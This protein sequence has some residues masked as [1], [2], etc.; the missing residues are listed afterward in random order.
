MPPD[1]PEPSGLDDALFGSDTA[2]NPI[3]RLPGTTDHGDALDDALFG[4][5]V[6]AAGPTGV[7]AD[8][9]DAADDAALFGT[10]AAP[11]RPPRTDDDTWVDAAAG[12]G[13]AAD[14]SLFDG[15]PG[16]VGAGATVRR[17][18]IDGSPRRGS[19]V[20]VA[21][22]AALLVLGLGGVA[23][24]VLATR[25]DGQRKPKV[26]VQG[27]SATA[28]SRPASTS[29]SSTTSTTAA[30]TTVAPTTT[31]TPPTTTQAPVA[32]TP[33]EPA[34]TGP[35]VVEP[36]PTEPPEPPTTTTAP[37]TTTTAPAQ[38]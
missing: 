27:V 35:P 28:S 37:A 18:P 12:A 10:E 26:K 8:E 4:T 21:A 22:V 38:P 17:A 23:Y 36:P 20:A 3:V 14:T 29:T 1:G 34:V 11:R 5:D 13:P 25:D 19:R 6:S 33:E 2:P 30:T 24:A 9:D 32:T 31:T 15:A 16:G 7:R